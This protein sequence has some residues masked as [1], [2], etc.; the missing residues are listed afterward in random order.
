MSE[1]R[2]KLDAMHSVRIPGRL[3]AELSLLTVRQIT[4]MNEHYLYS[5]ASQPAFI[6]SQAVAKKADR[7]ITEN[8]AAPGLPPTLFLKQTMPD[9]LASEKLEVSPALRHYFL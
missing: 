6:L 4:A 2:E 9:S 5:F 1:E 7:L 3:K 8:P